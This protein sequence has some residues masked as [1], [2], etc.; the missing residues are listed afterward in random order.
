LQ[1]HGDPIQFK[2]IYIKELREKKDV[3]DPLEKAL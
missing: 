2:N 1:N 3:R